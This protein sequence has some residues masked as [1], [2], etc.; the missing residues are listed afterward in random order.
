VAVLIEVPALA[1]FAACCVMIALA[2]AYKQTLGALLVNLAALLASV[3]IPTGLFGRVHPLRFA[4]DALNALDNAILATL[5]AGIKGTEWAYHK[6]L[7]YQAYVWQELSAT[8]ADLARETWHSFD[9]LTHTTVPRQIEQAI[10]AARGDATA[11][12]RTLRNDLAAAEHTI[13]TDVARLTRDAAAADRAVTTRLRHAEATAEGA[14][15]AAIAAT[16]PRV[17][18]VEKELGQV[19]DRLRRI[20]RTLTP[21]G[22]AALVLSALGAL[23]LGWVRC[24]NVK[25][26]GKAACRMD[27]GL[28]DALLADTALIL[29]TVSLVE[30]AHGMQGLTA[31]LE[32][33]VRRFWRAG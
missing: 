19:G 10:A 28:L 31:E 12:V 33:D 20:A 30:F 6:M 7:H 21:A 5:G 13:T 14:A 24:G 16:L 22:V 32:H 29:G 23:G 18:T 9:T 3:A 25:D 15:T 2:F 27:R 11:A 8:V 1:A 26:V 17:R 4:A